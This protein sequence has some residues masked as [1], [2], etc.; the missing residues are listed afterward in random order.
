MST[1][2]Y[3]RQ[4]REAMLRTSRKWLSAA[5]FDMCFHDMKLVCHRWRN[6]YPSSFAKWWCTWLLYSTYRVSLL[7]GEN[8][9]DVQRMRRG[10][11]VRTKADLKSII[12]GS[13]PLKIKLAS[14]KCTAILYATVWLEY[15]FCTRIVWNSLKPALVPQWRYRTKRH[16]LVIW[17]L[18][19]QSPISLILMKCPISKSIAFTRQDKWRGKKVGASPNC[20]QCSSAIVISI[21]LCARRRV[22]LQRPF[23]L[24]LSAFSSAWQEHRLFLILSLF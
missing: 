4:H 11:C 5:N 16:G 13:A 21:S 6:S 23:N 15:F 17:G 10:C 19:E 9:T 20:S 14:C 7:L 22:L 8:C 3:S 1:L 18:S 2:A 24:Q 12:K